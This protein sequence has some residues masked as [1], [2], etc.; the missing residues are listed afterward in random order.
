MIVPTVVA[1]LVLGACGSVAAGPGHGSRGTPTPTPSHSAS[2]SP[3]SALTMAD[4]GHTVTMHPGQ[5]VRVMLRAAQGFKPWSKPSSSDSSVLEPVVDPAASAQRGVTIASFRAVKPGSARLESSTS[6][7][8]A[9]G[10]V[11]PMLAR[12]WIVDVEVT[13]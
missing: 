2:P 10:Q 12:T 7:A 8:C 9:S 4:A 3:A 5:V 11:C 13:G 1:A 6:M